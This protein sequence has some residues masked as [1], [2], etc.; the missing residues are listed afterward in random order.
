MTTLARTE[1]RL[2]LRDPTPLLVVVL[3]PAAVLAALG[4]IPAL[5]EPAAVFGGLRFTDYFA[6][7]LL[8]IGIAA[9]GLQ[10]MPTTLATYRERGILR[11]LSTTPMRPSAVLLAQLVINVVAAAAGTAVMVAVAVL[12]F[13]VPAPR[14]PLGFL[15]AFVLGT[16]AVFGLGLLIAA[17]APRAKTATAVGSLLFVVSQ[18]FS[19]V[20]LPKF[21]LPEAMVRI[22]EYVPPG[23]GAFQAAWLGAGPAPDQLAAMAAVALL[24]TG[25]AARFFRWE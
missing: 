5:R 12:G 7:S 20:Y 21:L 6:P 25:A 17:I 14:H 2:Y 24:T 16:A 22:G 1:A 11:R 13:G 23:I 4:A 3:L 18:L 10:T 9:S 15:A 19:G 8:A